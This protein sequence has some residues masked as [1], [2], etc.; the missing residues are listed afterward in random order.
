MGL[1][2]RG[3]PLAPDS[4]DDVNYRIESPAHRLFFDEF[5]RRVRAVFNGET[6]F[7]TR[8]GKLLHESA[9]L[10]VLYVPDDDIRLDLLEPTDHHTHCPFKGDALYWSV[11]VSGRTAENAAWAYPEPIETARWLRGYRAFYF[12][13]MDAWFD[14]DEEVEGHLRDPYHRVDARGSSQR[15]RVLVDGEVVAD[16][17][18]PTVLSETGLPN[19]YY[20]PQDDLA[21]D[22]LVPS[23][24]RTHC[25]YKG[26]AS[27]YSVEVAERRVA[28]AGW[29][30]VE[31]L[32]DAAKVRDLVAFYPDKVVVEVDGR[33]VD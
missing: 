14:E 23:T 29:Y 4:P 11:V 18:H 2:L 13:E 30:Y 17:H 22:L 3:G 28:D 12:H 27:Y 1:T 33:I 9:I 19:R 16:T 26:D 6:I 25:P 31:P 32:E 20:I 10:P 5:P 8:G 21:D 7:D 15:V 24:S